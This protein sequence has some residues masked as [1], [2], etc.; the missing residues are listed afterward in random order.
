MNSVLSLGVYLLCALGLSALGLLIWD[1]ISAAI[2]GEAPPQGIRERMR[3]NAPA[4]IARGQYLLL[5]SFY[6]IIMVALISVT[7]FKHQYKALDLLS[8]GAVAFV[9]T[10][11]FYRYH[12]RWRKQQQASTTSPS[13][14]QH[15]NTVG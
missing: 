10:D 13:S 9:W 6:F 11:C 3:M 12:V 2:T 15:V 1:A 7:I 8:S 4:P 5:T 14:D